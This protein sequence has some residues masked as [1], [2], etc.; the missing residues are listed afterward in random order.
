MIV[1][2]KVW[3]YKKEPLLADGAWGT[4]LLKRGLEHGCSPEEWNLSNP[5]KVRD[6][7]LKYLNAGSRIILTNTFGG[8]SIQLKRHGIEGKAIDINRIGA[9]LTSSAVNGKAVVAGSMGPSGKM[10]LMGE[11][12]EDELFN[13]FSAQA[14]ALKQGGADWIVV[15]TMIDIEEMAIAVRAASMETGLPVVASMTY[16]KTKKGE[17]RTIMGNSLDDC[18][19]RAVKEGA[20]IVGA[21]CGTGIENYI[22]LARELCSVSSVPVWIKANAGVPELIE[23]KVVYRMTPEKYAEYVLQL[24]NAGVNVLGGCCGTDPEYIKKIKIV[25]DK[26]C[27]NRGKITL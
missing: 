19:K 5:D 8:N 9:E 12:T 1:L 2:G 25:I 21:N 6:I 20:S 17:Y 22:N 11:V 18:F 26:Y 4:E 3:D 10:L 24:L 27:S 15:E 16:E 13:S 14:G 7:A 23:G